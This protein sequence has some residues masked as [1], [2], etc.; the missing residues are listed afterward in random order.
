MINQPQHLHLHKTDIL[1]KTMVL[2]NLVTEACR[3]IDPVDFFKKADG[4]WSAAEELEHLNLSIRAT[5]KA[6]NLPEFLLVWTA[7][8]PA[9]IARS[10]QESLKRYERKLAEG[11][12]DNRAFL[13]QL[14]H[15]NAGELIDQWVKN[16][17]YYGNSLKYNRTNFSLDDLQVKHP[18]LGKITLRELCYF[19]LYHTDHHLQKIQQRHSITSP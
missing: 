1:E 2:F 15:H 4:H 10:Y 19:T 11:G 13:P 9:T 8:R 6:F 3:Q 5:S 16:S 7:G 12:W 17:T 18:V 14:K